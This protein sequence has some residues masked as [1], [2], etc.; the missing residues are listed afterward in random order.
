MACAGH[1]GRLYVVAN[2]LRQRYCCNPFVRLR[3]KVPIHERVTGDELFHA[4]PIELFYHSFMQKAFRYSIS[5]LT[6]S[7]LNFKKFD[8]SSSIGLPSMG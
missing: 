4:R 1:A 5:D 3:M 8:Y 2:G 6:R 7:D